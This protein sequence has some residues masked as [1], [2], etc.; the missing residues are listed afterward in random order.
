[1]AK[2]ITETMQ[3]HT[4]I[5]RSQDK[6]QIFEFTKEYQFNGKSALVL[7]LSS[8]SDNTTTTFDRTKYF[9]FI[10]LSSM[11]FNTITLFN[12]FPKI[13]DTFKSSSY[14]KADMD[15]SL[16]YLKSLLDK[17]YDT[18]IVAFGSSHS[19]DKR[20]KTTKKEVFE[21]LNDYLGVSSI[22]RIADEFSSD[23]ENNLQCLHPLYCGNYLA[24]RWKLAPFNLEQAI[25][26]LEKK[27][28]PKQKEITEV[29]VEVNQNDI[30]EE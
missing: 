21:L 4:T 15:E 26:N 30:R 24:L 16:K 3:E 27:S 10:N 11:G 28:P 8:E 5:V 22:C 13:N 29:K 7:T 23:E 12:V 2:K 20:V 6:T 1:M 14:T 19:T 18:V 17:K 25:A 9:T